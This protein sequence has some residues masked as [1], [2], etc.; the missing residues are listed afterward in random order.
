MKVVPSDHTLMPFFQNRVGGT[1]DVS[2]SPQVG[3]VATWYTPT[4]IGT[5]A[6]ENRAS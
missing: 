1:L 5:F 4:R 3:S 2:G 6:D